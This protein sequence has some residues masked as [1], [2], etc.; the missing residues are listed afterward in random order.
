MVINGYA[1]NLSDGNEV[2]I[3]PRPGV[4]SCTATHDDFQITI[5]LTN[6]SFVAKSLNQNNLML[7]VVQFRLASFE[8][9][10]DGL[11]ENDD[12]G[13]SGILWCRASGCCCNCGAGWICG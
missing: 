5:N 10:E 4:S 12:S 9:P 6:G 2:L 7:G 1:F 3:A 13:N 8:V 11:R